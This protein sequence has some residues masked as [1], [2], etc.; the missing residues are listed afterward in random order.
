M[1]KVNPIVLTAQK[2]ACRA[3]IKATDRQSTEDI[4]RFRRDS[5]LKSCKRKRKITENKSWEV[6]EEAWKKGQGLIPSSYKAG[7]QK[8]L[9]W[10]MGN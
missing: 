8:T 9:R 7:S 1:I 4:H 2:Q 3:I 5:E 6:K 10:L